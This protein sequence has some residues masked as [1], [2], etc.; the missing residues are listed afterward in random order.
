MQLVTERAYASPGAL[1]FGSPEAD[2][3]RKVTNN[4]GVRI[5]RLLVCDEEGKLLFAAEPDGLEV[6]GLGLESGKQAM[7]NRCA[8]QEAET[9]A[10]LSF[11]K[12]FDQHAPAAPVGM[13][14]YGSQN[15]WRW[16]G[17]RRM[18][19]GSQKQFGVAK[20]GLEFRLDELRTTISAGTL[21]PRSYVAIVERPES[22]S[23]GLDDLSETESTHVIHGRW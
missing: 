18:T 14:P 12:R 1:V 2:G 3:G 16:F 11:L 19:Y 23:A 5:H 20:T 8:T 21:E 4:L 7:L 15:A 17:S 22:V 9:A 13:D 6:S 10:T